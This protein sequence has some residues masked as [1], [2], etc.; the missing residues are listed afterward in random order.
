MSYFD[1]SF[2]RTP[3][4]PREISLVPMINVIFLMLIFF[5]IAGKI[6]HVHILPINIPLS[7]QT[8]DVSLGEELITLGKRDEILIG[9]E[10]IFSLDELEAWIKERITTNPAVRFTIKADA[11]MPAT[12]LINVMQL[13]ERAGAHDVVLAAQQP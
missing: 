2:A 5:I 10:P 4:K 1:V 8:S 6:E 11:D 13:M 12:I 9:E 7:E 3:R